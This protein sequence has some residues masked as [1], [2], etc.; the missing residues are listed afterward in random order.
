MTKEQLI[1]TIKEVAERHGFTTQTYQWTRFIEI[2]EADSH[3]LNFYISE[4]PAA[5]S[6][7]SKRECTM[8]VTIFASLASMGGNPTVEDLLKASDIIRKGALMV[9]ELGDM[10]LSYQA[11]I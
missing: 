10:K 3:Y 9:Q 6:D 11:S 5:D 1:A 7:W 2:Q 4:R 8:E